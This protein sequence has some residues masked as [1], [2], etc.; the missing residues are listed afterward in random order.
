MATTASREIKSALPCR[1]R[2]RP[3]VL[4][5]RGHVRHGDGVPPRQRSE[6]SRPRSSLRRLSADKRIPADERTIPRFGRSFL[7]SE[8]SIA[9]DAVRRARI[10]TEKEAVAS[11]RRCAVARVL[12]WGLV[13][14]LP[15]VPL[16]RGLTRR[17]PKKFSRRFIVKK[18]VIGSAIALGLAVAVAGPLGCSSGSHGNSGSGDTQGPGNGGSRQHQHATH[19]PRRRDHHER[20]LDD[21][22]GRDR[23][24]ERHL[25]RSR[26]RDDDQLQH[27]ERRGGERLHDHSLGDLARRQGHVRRH[28]GDVLRHRA[29]DDERKRVP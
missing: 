2:M 22:P 11:V 9:L 4:Q 7:E 14:P 27:P 5:G 25:R 29:D 16:R 8:A 15:R 12:Y 28:V 23:R 21:Q 3:T 26:R 6:L 1:M 18:S 19:A 17:N 10:P 24:A 13:S 20:Q